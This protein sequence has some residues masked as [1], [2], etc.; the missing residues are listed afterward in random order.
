MS[1]RSRS[2]ERT[3]KASFA[4]FR[5]PASPG[6][7]P[8]RNLASRG[9][10]LREFHQNIY[11]LR[12]VQ[13]AL[14]QTTEATGAKNDVFVIFDHLL[15]Q[16]HSN[17]SS[18]RLNLNHPGWRFDT[19]PIGNAEPICTSCKEGLAIAR[20]LHSSLPYAASFSDRVNRAAP[21]SVES[22]FP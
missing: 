7:R 12:P 19:R 4:Q 3:W 20:H 10:S 16:K 6:I 5:R 14:Q 11:S 15:S 8:A 2:L 17:H 22:Q 9:R 1:P 18:I 13:F 21:E